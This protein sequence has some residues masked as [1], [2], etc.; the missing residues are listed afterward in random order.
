LLANA[1]VPQPNL[2]IKAFFNLAKV[3]NYQDLLP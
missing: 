2:Q 3:L 1:N